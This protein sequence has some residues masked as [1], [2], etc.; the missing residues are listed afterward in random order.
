M[1]SKPF[2]WLDFE[3]WGI[4]PGIQAPPPVC[5][6]YAIDDGPPGLLHARDPR[7]WGLLDTSFSTNTVIVAH[8]SPYEV[9]VTLANALAMKLG[10]WSARVARK[11]DAYEIRC[12]Q[13][14]QKSISVARGD[15]QKKFNLE[16]CLS[17]MGS[18]VHVD[19]SFYGRTRYGTLWNTP[20]EQF[21]AD[22][23]DYALGDIHCRTLYRL[24]EQFGGQ[25]LVERD[26]ILQHWAD[27]CLKSMSAWGFRV[28]PKTA[29]VLRDE[30]IAKLDAE[31]A[32]LVRC[33]LLKVVAAPDG[34][35]NY[36]Q[37]RTLAK[38]LIVQ[39]YAAQGRE[40]PR[41]ELTNIALV[42]AYKLAGL[43]CP[44]I[45]MRAKKPTEGMIEDA[46]RAGVPPEL[47][48]GSVSTDEEACEFSRN[49][50]L[51]AL[52]RFSKA[53]GILAR[54]H[55]LVRAAELGIPIQAHFN[56]LLKSGRTSCS[57]GDDPA[58]GEPYASYGYQLQNLGRQGDVVWVED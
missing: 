23:R 8:N 4:V 45:D 3:T 6:A 42:K 47:L 58:P 7:F 14:R 31:R 37:N 2:L 9:L 48:L 46:R 32:D 1:V 57:N 29:R 33:G 36:Q 17:A 16:A 19:K 15:L 13:T 18:S 20:I 22:Y 30:T 27:V 41:C 10:N 25:Y 35:I 52:S 54:A 44:D 24:Q 55:R 39:A 56:N 43:P 53:T 49:E 12:T 40:P 5:V 11:L 26:Q 21:P 50:R 51:K 38:E 34:T 28:D